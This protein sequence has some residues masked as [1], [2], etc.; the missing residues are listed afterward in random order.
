MKKADEAWEHPKD[1]MAAETRKEYDKRMEWWANDKFGMFIHWGIYSVPEGEWKGNKNHAEWIMNTGHIPVET[2]EKFAA[3]FNPVK[4][5]ADQWVAAAK[6]AGMKYIVITSKHHDGFCMFDSKFTKYDIMDA[7]PFKRDVLKELT[8][9]CHRQGVTM[10][11][12]HSIMD[13]HH[14]DYTPRRKW[15]KRSAEGADYDRYVNHMRKQLAELICKYHP[16][17]IWFDG[18]WEST[19]THE[20]GKH[21]YNYLRTL[22]PELIINNRVDKGRSGH[23]GAHDRREYAGDFG[24]PE[25]HIPATGMPKGYY[26]ETCMT[27][28]NHWGWNKCDDNFKSTEDLLHKLVDIVS[29][30]GNF[31]LN[32]GPKPDGTIPEQSLERM[33]EIG[34]WMRVNGESIYGT[35]ANMFDPVPW[36][37]STTKGNTLY[38]HVFEWPSNGKLELPGLISKPD[39][40]EV[41]AT[42]ED[43]KVK[44]TASG[45]TL[46]LPPKPADPYDTVVKLTFSK[47]P[48]VAT[49][50]KIKGEKRFADKTRIVIEKGGSLDARYTLDGSDPTADSPLY[51]KPFTIRDTTIVKARSFKGRRGLAEI[52]EAKF[53]KLKMLKSAKPAGKT[54]K[55]LNYALYEGAWDNL[56]DFSKLKPVK[57]GVCRGF[58]LLKIK[59]DRTNNYGIVFE[60]YI[61][62]PK[63]GLYEATLSSDDGS[64]LYID[65]E[66]VVDNDGLHA[67]EAKKDRIVLEKGLH[68]IR[69]EF[70][71]LGGDIA[72]SLDLKTPSGKTIKA[73][74]KNLFRVKK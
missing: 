49:A 16:A 60:G 73:T 36:G 48:Q 66:P 59:G 21:L 63:S 62:V 19:W 71:Q 27:M 23:K 70:F 46:S 25:Q 51:T 5:D 9:A 33:R 4:F 31:L 74:P 41:L 44:M 61:K 28:N 24:T 18:Q 40:A 55:G 50:P 54:V 10:C 53:Y 35:T 14:P 12:Y 64:K 45:A 65:G 42:G 22:D 37:R 67:N 20:Y 13:W 72:L 8:E 39:G 34:K 15:E 26:W 52:A 2:Y 68:R 57:K 43:V 1:M 58:D 6:D 32:V 56:P 11:F 38:L 69:V 30:G 47:P 29:K 7:T 3:R 17:L